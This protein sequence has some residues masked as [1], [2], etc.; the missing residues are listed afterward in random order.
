MNNREE[1]LRFLKGVL[2]G[3]LVSAVVSAVGI[4]GAKKV[5]FGKESMNVSE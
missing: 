3:V 2:C 1:R 5:Y 4:Y